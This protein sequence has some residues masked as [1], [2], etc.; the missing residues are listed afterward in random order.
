[1]PSVLIVD[2]EPH[3]RNLLVRILSA[4]RPELELREAADAPA[5]FRALA[6]DAPDLLILDLGL[7]GGG[8]LGVCRALWSLP[9]PRRPRVLA[10]SGQCT[11]ERREEALR[12]GAEAFV[13]KPFNLDEMV[14]AAAALL[15]AERLEEP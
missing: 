10:M 12:A 11:P 15:E 4:A 1:M 7:P 14:R 8:G 2:D 3:I 5:A 13:G 9:G 6:E